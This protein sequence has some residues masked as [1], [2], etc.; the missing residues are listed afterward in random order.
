MLVDF[1]S[2][3]AYYVYTQHIII[4]FGATCICC[5]GQNLQQVLDVE[6]IS[7]CTH[8]KYS[9]R[10]SNPCSE[11]HSYILWIEL[12]MISALALDLVSTDPD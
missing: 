2:V 10:G 4:S 8:G 5:L 9:S 12:N 6:I 11:Y 1:Y 3:L 7:R